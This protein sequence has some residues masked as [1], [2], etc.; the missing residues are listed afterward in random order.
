M[1]EGLDP[2]SSRTVYLHASQPTIHPSEQMFSISAVPDVERLTCTQTPG[3]AYEL[4]KPSSLSESPGPRVSWPG[5]KH[6]IDT[7]MDEPNRMDVEGR[8]TKSQQPLL[9][10]PRGRV[11]CRTA[12]S[13]HQLNLTV[14]SVAKYSSQLEV[15]A[16]PMY[17]RMSLSDCGCLFVCA[18]RR[19]RRVRPYP[20]LYH[21]EEWRASL[22]AVL[23]PANGEAL[24]A[25]ASRVTADL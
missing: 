2:H 19:K 3:M 4:T 21:E 16:R 18:R 22:S 12:Q 9:H 1:V 6:P 5:H 20:F 25:P 13:N 8:Y 23:Y 15:C 24:S 17:I 14:T 11:R 10:P 7:L